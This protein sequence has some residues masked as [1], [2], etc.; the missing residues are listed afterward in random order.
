MVPSHPI[1]PSR[2]IALSSIVPSHPIIQIRLPNPTMQ[3][4]LITPRTLRKKPI[5]WICLRKCSKELVQGT[6]P[7]N[8]SK[9]LVKRNTSVFL[10]SKEVSSHFSLDFKCPFFSSKWLKIMTFFEAHTPNFADPPPHSLHNV[11]NFLSFL[12]LPYSN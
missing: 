10:K 2:L 11:W 6:V 5:P 3:P 9:D 8:L 4:S 12:W 7:R 1:L